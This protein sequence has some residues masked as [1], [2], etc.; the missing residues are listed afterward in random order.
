[1]FTDLVKMGWALYGDKGRAPRRNARVRGSIPSAPPINPPRINNVAA[2]SEL[3]QIFRKW[4]IRDQKY[5]HTHQGTVGNGN[6]VK[7]V[8]SVTT[9]TDESIPT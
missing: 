8:L 4:P 6:H 2:R 5:L 3:R 1:M 7:W 9:A